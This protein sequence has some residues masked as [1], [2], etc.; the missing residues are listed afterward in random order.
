MKNRSEDINQALYS[1]Q[2]G[3]LERCYKAAVHEVDPDF[4]H[5]NLEGIE[6]NEAWSWPCMRE[7]Q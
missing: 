4:E 7:Q 3:E 2:S 1:L 6:E 5:A